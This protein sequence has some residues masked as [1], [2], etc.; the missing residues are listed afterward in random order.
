[1][2]TALPTASS[3]YG[4]EGPPADATVDNAT[5]QG[6][7]YHRGNPVQTNGASS[8]RHRHN[9]AKGRKVRR[10]MGYIA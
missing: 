9:N 5:P 10:V 1:M 4:L 3:A 7:T 6:F 2:S 8:L